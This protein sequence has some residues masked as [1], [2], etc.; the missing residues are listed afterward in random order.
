MLEAFIGRLYD[1]NML[2]EQKNFNISALFVLIT[3]IAAVV[4]AAVLELR[5]DFYWMIFLVFLL[6]VVSIYFGN[7]TGQ[8]NV[9]AFVISIIINLIE[10]PA[11]YVIDGRFICSVPVYFTLGVFFC[12]FTM[13]GKLKHV[14]VVLCML[15]CF[16]SALYVFVR[17]GADEASSGSVH[18]IIDIIVP[19]FICS[20]ISGVAV[21]FKQRIYNYERKKAED[22]EAR[23]VQMN[24]AKDVFLMNMS[25]EIRTPMNAIISASELLMT[26]KLGDDM[27]Q[28]V[29]YILNACDALL[30]GIND[31][32][33][34]SKVENAGIVFNDMEYS[35]ADIINDIVNMIS[36]RLMDSDI[37]F[38]VSMDADIPRV[39][40]GDPARMRQLFINLLNNAVKYTNTGHIALKVSAAAMNQSSD[41]EKLTQIRVSVEDTGI[42]IRE[43]NL[44]GLFN[45]FQRVED[46]TH[47]S[48]RIEGT[49]LGLSICREILNS[50]DGHIEVKSEYNKGSVFSFSIPQKII[51]GSPIID[52]ACLE[53]FSV[54]AMESD[55]MKAKALA[56]ALGGCHVLYSLADTERSFRIQLQNASFSHILISSDCCSALEDCIADAEAAGVKVIVIADINRTDAAGKRQKLI[57]PVYTMNTANA[58]K[59]DC[60]ETGKTAEKEEEICCPDA[61]VMVIDDNK[62]NLM[63][64][65]GLLSK[66]GMKVTT[67]SGGREA[68][69]LLSSA[70][71][72]MIFIDYMMPD[73]DGI[74][75][76]NSIRSQKAEWLKKVPCIV[77]TADAAAGARE[78]LLEA[79]FDDY[80]SKPIDLKK[81]DRCI[82]TFMRP[83]LIEVK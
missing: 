18:I 67:V 4:S 28:N 47:D 66:Y 60:R 57:R 76:L 65:D 19:L 5:A 2:P 56:D 24:Q 68:L 82:R 63:V 83:E 3:Y 58:L 15:S 59:T 39:F 29:I 77:L 30:S 73:M 36:V 52:T 43:E 50:A 40:Y 80:I 12:A 25:H 45:A 78:M 37:D 8:F 11:A 14:A 79:G 49:G 41:D 55:P 48:R 53:H 70:R 32:L 20:V 9:W 42:G 16:I 75:T 64:A 62:T 7:R 54:L 38:Y 44:A 61:S 81:L 6:T 13:S 33:D 22:E 21:I 26:K 23:S 17:S 51:D 27:K 69:N 46:D 72:D 71:A 10:L 34:F 1:R 74:D 35:I 31:L